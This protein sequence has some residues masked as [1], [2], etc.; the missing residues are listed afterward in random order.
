MLLPRRSLRPFNTTRVGCR[1][2]EVMSPTERITYCR[3][4]EPL[5]GMVATV[6]RRRADASCGPTP[7]TRSPRGFACPKGIAMAEVQNDPDRRPAPAAAPPRR[8][9]R[10]GLLGRRP[11]RDRR[12]PRRDPRPSTAASRSAGTWG[13]RARSATRTRS[14]SRA[15]STRSARRTP[16]PPPPRT[17]PTGSPPARSSTARRSCVP[18]PDLARTDFLLV[19]GANPLVSHGSVLSA[20]RIK[21]Q[22]HAIIER[23]GRVVVVDPAPLRDRARV[24]APADRPGRRRLAA[25]LA[26]RR[27]LRRGRSRTAPRSA[28]GDRRRRPARARRDPSARGHR[29]AQRGRRPIA[30]ASWPRDLAAA[31]R[32][33]VYGRTGSCLGRNGTL[34]SFLL[35]ALNVVT[36][37]LDRD[38]GAMFGDPPIR[39]R[40]GRRGDRRRRLRQAP[41]AGRRPP[42]GARLD[43]RLA[44]GEGDHHPG[45]GPDPGDVRLR[46][47]PGAVV[48]NGDEL[49]AAIAELELCVSIDLYVSETASSPTTCCRRRRFLEREDFPLPFLSLFTNAV[50]PVTEA[51]VE[52][53][54]E[55]RQ[56]WEVIEDIAARIG[57]V[58]SSVLAA[59]WLGRAG[60]KLSPRRLVDLLLRVGPEGDLFGLRRGGLSLKRLAQTRTGSSSPSTSRRACSTSKIRHARRPGA[61]LPRRDRG[62]GRTDRPERSR[63]GRRDFPLR[64]IGLRELRSHNSWM[65]NSAEADGGG[66]GPSSPASIPPTQR[67][68]GSQTAIGSGSHRPTARSRSR[69]GSP[70]RSSPARSPFRTAGATSRLG[71]GQRRRRGERQPAHLLGARRPRAAGRDGAPERRPGAGRRRR[72][73]AVKRC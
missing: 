51:V 41:L 50:H 58:P 35:D 9:V 36:G 53:R 10:A 65:H 29:G 6:D 14:G 62:R 31:E 42:R 23:G 54:G 72:A 22:L 20:P 68:P 39:L 13:T 34:V 40:P 46:R 1:R 24:R 52:P 56:E 59:R 55:A 61:S 32:A 7:T 64:M 2:E 21:D 73:G 12:A 28:P 45:E 18:I 30:S 60:L 33:A 3:I 44:D 57:I 27:D 26:P 37:N 69:P 63:A 38:G 8:L 67:R 47:Q 48:P 70:T 17:S 11:R 71:D 19:V 43:A 49:E 66:S 4:C 15:S 25:A 16:T 5:C